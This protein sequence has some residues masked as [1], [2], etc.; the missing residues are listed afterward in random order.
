MGS[1]SST[2][3]TRWRRR[4]TR[5]TCGLANALDMAD[6]TITY[7]LIVKEVAP[8]ARCLRDVH[9]EAAVRRERL[10]MHTHHVALQGRPQPVL[11]RRR[12]VPPLRWASSSSPACSSH[13]REFVAVFAQWVN[14]YK[15]LVPGLRGAGLRRL[16]AAEPLGAH[17]HPAVQAGLRAGDPGRDCC[18]DPACNPY[19]TFAALLHAGLEGIEKGYELPDPMETN[20][21]H[22]TSEERRERGIVSLP[23]TLGEAIDALYASDL[24]S[25]R[26]R[27]HIFGNYIEAEAQGVGRLPRPAHAVGARPLPLGSLRLSSLRPG[28]AENLLP[29]HREQILAAFPR[30]RVKERS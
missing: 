10:G 20:L 12:S 2:T 16:V 15:R 13:A 26:D 9:A 5:S 4:S 3:T 29:P 17:P 25:K 30:K 11:R 27:H 24:V 18:P 1:P 22:L 28:D 6:K 8:R 19:L 7:R 21:Y 23:E 14:S